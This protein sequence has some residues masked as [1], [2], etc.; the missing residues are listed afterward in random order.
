M[1]K[2]PVAPRLY[3]SVDPVQVRREDIDDILV[4]VQ[5]LMPTVQIESQGYRFDSIEELVERRGIRPG[6]FSIKAEQSSHPYLLLEVEFRES[7]VIL[8]VSDTDRFGAAVFTL[9]DRVERLRY[10]PGGWLSSTRWWLLATALVAVGSLPRLHVYA[11]IPLLSASLAAYTASF[12]VVPIS[13]KLR[14][15]RLEHRHRGGFFRRNSDSLLL[16]I[17]GALFGGLVTRLIEWATGKP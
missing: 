8:S 9:R 2:L 15:V 3:F 7:D 17:G 14:G 11:R 1:E 6:R 5:Q 10:H 16:L 13:Q 12:A 4:I